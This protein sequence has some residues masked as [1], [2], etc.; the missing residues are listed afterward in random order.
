MVPA[1]FFGWVYKVAFISIVSI[2]AN[3]AGDLAAARADSN[4]EILE[5]L[6]RL[7]KLILEI[8]KGVKDR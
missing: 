6:D 7:E 3:A 1:Y 2:Y 4:R 5:R 8:N